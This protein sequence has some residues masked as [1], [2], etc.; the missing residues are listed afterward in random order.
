M[1]DSLLEGF[2]DYRIILEAEELLF[3]Q[4]AE[5]DSFY[6]IQEGLADVI[7]EGQEETFITSL[8]P[9]QLVGEMALLDDNLKRSA[10]VRARTEISCVRFSEQQFEDLLESNQKFRQLII[11]VLVKRLRKTTTKMARLKESR[12]LIYESAFVLMENLSE[13]EW[14]GQQSI[15]RSIEP[16]ISVFADGFDISPGLIE[17]ML[18]APNREK[19]EL[20]PPETQAKLQ[21]TARDILETGLDKIEFT[22]S[23]EKTSEE[24]PGETGPDYSD[25]ETAREVAKK[26]YFQ[27][28]KLSQEEVSREKLNRVRE[29]YELLKARMKRARENKEEDLYIRRQLDA[30][31]RSLGRTYQKFVD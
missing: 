5:A 2:E 9:R 30:Y 7:K 15:E 18:G 25:L 13:N 31:V 23:Y 3:E 4:G 11:K 16:D 10:T 6:I 12:K 24:E 28:R 27:L 17:Q 26:L 29:E 8:G 21:E 19:L 20:K 14:D 22:T 1:G